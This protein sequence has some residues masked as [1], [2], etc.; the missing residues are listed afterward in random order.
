MLPQAKCYGLWQ[1][2]PGGVLHLRVSTEELLLP[3]SPHS[4][5]VAHPPMSCCRTYAL[6]QQHTASTTGTDGS[7]SSQRG[8]SSPENTQQA[9]STAGTREHLSLLKGKG[10]PTSLQAAGYSK[11][12]A[13]CAVRA[14]SAPPL[15]PVQLPKTPSK[16]HELHAAF[17]CR[18]AVAC[19]PHRMCTNRHPPP[20]WHQCSCQMLSHQEDLMTKRRQKEGMQVGRWPNNADVMIRHKTSLNGLHTGKRPDYRCAGLIML[21]TASVCYTMALS[22]AGSTLLFL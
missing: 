10:H 11:A 6:T 3:V 4:S 22:W 7:S 19:C 20:I 16:R 18:A 9:S 15:V 12:W 2:T 14:A 21:Y 17:C 13:G 1:S 5:V 8:S